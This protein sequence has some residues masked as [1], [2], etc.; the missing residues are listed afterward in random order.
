MWDTALT[1]N[2]YVAFDNNNI[3]TAFSYE[4]NID[5]VEDVTT[6]EKALF[7]MGEPFDSD[8]NAFRWHTDGEMDIYMVFR[9]ARTVNEKIELLEK[10]LLYRWFY[11]PHIPILMNGMSTTEVYQL[12]GEADLVIGTAGVAVCYWY[13]DEF[14]VELYGD[15]IRIYQKENF[16]PRTL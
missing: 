12:M 6:I 14:V 5:F 3:A 16:N 11:M 9:V 8:Y 15:S 1:S 7:I 10:P 13:V 4:E 2:L